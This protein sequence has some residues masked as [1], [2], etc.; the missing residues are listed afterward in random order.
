[1]T[2]K[3]IGDSTTSMPKKFM[4]KKGIGYLESKI[5]IEGKDYKDLTDIN[6]LDFIK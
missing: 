2:I 6:R 5:V 1:M 4:E 3:L